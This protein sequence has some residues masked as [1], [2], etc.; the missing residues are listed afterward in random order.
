MSVGILFDSFSDNVGDIAM[1]AA[2]QRL[3]ARHGVDDIVPVDLFSTAEQSFSS[4]LVGGGELI[5]PTGS[6]FYD[7]FRQENAT[8]L[9]AVGVWQ[10]ADDLDYLKRYAFVSARTRAEADV[11]ERSGISASVLP[12]PT[13]ALPI[14]DRSVEL[15]SDE[16]LIG[17]HVVPASLRDVPSLL[18][19]LNGIAGRKVMVPFT[20]YL[21]DASFLNA[22][23]IGDS[24]NVWLSTA[25][26]PIQLRGVVA[27][28]SFVV[29]SSLHLTLF[30]LS[31]GIPFVSYGQPKVSAYLNDRGLQDLVFT[32]DD[33]LVR[34]LSCARQMRDEISRIGREEM[35][36]IEDEYSAIARVFKERLNDKV[37]L[38]AMSDDREQ[39][40][41]QLRLE[42][43]SH[44]L[45]GRD[46][47]INSLIHAS[48][49]R[50]VLRLLIEGERQSNKLLMEE[51]NKPLSMRDILCATRKSI[52]A[53]INVDS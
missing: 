6:L 44:V 13:M 37:T 14:N 51:L 46:M 33:S 47:L 25:L 28:L 15:P 34:A 23:P 48:A 27:R 41:W 30:A 40:R 19:Q 50:D 45:A 18:T 43:V 10:D 42:Q 26:T 22:L 16:T 29:A 53:R 9:A 2:N 52:A 12:C 3:L 5:R 1:L 35:I 11:L 31:A 32:D 20:R 38:P 17:I 24:N 36:R 21:H 49:E 7:R 8:V 39:T 4:V